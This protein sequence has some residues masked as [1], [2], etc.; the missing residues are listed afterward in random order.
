MF[1]LF[2]KFFYL[3]LIV[4]KVHMGVLTYAICVILMNSI[5]FAQYDQYGKCLL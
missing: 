2:Y 3:N 1:H 5:V 4:Q